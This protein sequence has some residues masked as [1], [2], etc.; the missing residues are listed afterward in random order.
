MK[1]RRAFL[2]APGRMELRNIEVSPGPE[3]VLIKVAVCGLCNWELNHWKGLLG[4]CPQTLGHEWGGTVVEVGTEVPSLHIGDT[5]TGLSGDAMEGFSDYLVSQCTD[6]LKVS[7]HVAPE[8]ALGEPLKCVVT[9]LRGVAPEAGDIGVVVGCGP[10]GLWCIQGMAGALLSALIAVDRIPEKLELPRRFGATHTVDAQDEKVLERVVE[11][12]GGRMADFVVEGTGVSE[13]MN[14]GAQ[15]LKK[16]RG[17]LAM[18]SAH[19]RVSRQAFDWR[20]LQDKGLVVLGTHPPYSQNERDDLW[21]AKHRVEHIGSYPL[22]VFLPLCLL[23]RSFPKDIAD[24][25]FQI[26]NSCFPGIRAYDG[27]Q[28]GRRNLHVIRTQSILLQ[29]PRNE[30]AFRNDDLV[31]LN[32]SGKFDHLH[33]VQECIWNG[34]QAIGRGDKHDMRQV[35]C[36]FKIVIG[37]GM[38]LFRIKNLQQRG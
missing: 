28:G 21:R 24:L 4:T 37:K 17:R 29:L 13:M 10:M 25:T 32:V 38:V 9:V 11:I 3:E 34:V 1:T 23:A 7:P 6:C 31:F 15:Y 33:T 5:V 16:G 19:E 2:V 27:L 36:Q 22:R 14:Q 18:M 12:T 35:I 20:S 30:K 26:P 8:Q